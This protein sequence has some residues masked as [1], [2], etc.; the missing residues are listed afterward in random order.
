MSIEHSIHLLLKNLKEYKS[1]KDNCDVLSSLPLIQELKKKNEKLEKENRKLVKFILESARNQPTCVVASKKKGLRKKILATEHDAIFIETLPVKIK[2]EPIVIEDEN[3]Y[4]KNDD[5]VFTDT[6]SCV[7]EYKNALESLTEIDSSFVNVMI[8][9]FIKEELEDAVDIEEGDTTDAYAYTEEEKEPD[10]DA[11]EEE[12]T[13]A[14]TEEEDTTNAYTE[15]EKEPDVDA[16][17]EET[18]Q[19]VTETED[20]VIFK[21]SVVEKEVIHVTPEEEEE[22]VAEEVVEIFYENKKYYATDE[23]NG[24][25]FS[26][27]EDDDIGDEIGKIKNGKIKFYKKN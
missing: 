20:A 7:N 27:N 19:Y 4:I 16:E 8:E 14:Y 26:V 9:S 13:D 5:F 17:E 12:T 24:I 1:Y 3:I 11:E 21:S 22:E 25:V 15:E 2:K 6:A 10:V 23:Q 18:E